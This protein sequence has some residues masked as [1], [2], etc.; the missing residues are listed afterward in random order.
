MKTNSHIE[1]VCLSLVFLA[2]TLAVRGSQFGDFTYESSG[3]EIIITGYTGPGGNVT[4]PES[5]K[6]LPVRRIGGCA[7]QGCASL[8]SVTI[9]DSVTRI[10]SS[11]FEG[12]N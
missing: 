7:F 3:T 2:G 6:G 10:A 5:I 11:A 4:I 8:T 12:C 9:L 1:S